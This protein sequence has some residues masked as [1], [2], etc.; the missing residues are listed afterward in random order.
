[1]TANSLTIKITSYLSF[2]EVTSHISKRRRK[3]RHAIGNAII[4]LPSLILSFLL[5]RFFRV[6]TSTAS[7]ALLIYSGLRHICHSN[8]S[9]QIIGHS[10]RQAWFGRC[11]EAQFKVGHMWST[12]PNLQPVVL[13]MFNRL[14]WNYL[15]RQSTLA[16]DKPINRL[17]LFI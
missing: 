2:S 10:A 11:P 1:M 3:E 17:I 7:E 6:R 14:H 16:I 15:P 9:G 4:W 5:S 13:H 8:K 12:F